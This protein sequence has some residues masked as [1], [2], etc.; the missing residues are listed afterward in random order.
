MSGAAALQ[1]PALTSYLGKV[2]LAVDDSIEL[3]DGVSAKHDSVNVRTEHRGCLEPGKQK[4]HL[5]RGEWAC[6]LDR[7]ILVDKRRQHNRLDSR[8]PQ[9]GKSGG[10]GGGEVQAHW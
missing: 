9:G 6:G 10:R 4:H 3:E 5:D 8:G 1:N 7:G 2:R